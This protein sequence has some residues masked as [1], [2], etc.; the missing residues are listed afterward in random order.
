MIIWKDKIMNSEDG[1]SLQDPQGSEWSTALKES[2]GEA[3]T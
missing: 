3:G 1:N 2:A